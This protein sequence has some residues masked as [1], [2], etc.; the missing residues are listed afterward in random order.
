[1]YAFLTK[2]RISR[3]K[4][5]FMSTKSKK[6][7]KG[8]LLWFRAVLFILPKIV[9][10]YFRLVDLTSR[11][12]H[13]NRQIEEEVCKRKSFCLA[14]FHGA[15]LW[16]TYC[17]RKF[18]GIIMVSRSWDGELI[19]RCLR[20]WGYDTA[21]GSSSKFG[22]EALQDMV[23]LVKE[24]GCNA[25]MAVDAPRGPARVAKIG[26]V[27]IARDTGQ[28]I[29]PIATW[30][31]RHIQFNSWDKMILPLPFGT[32]VVAYGDP[33]HVPKGLSHAGY[34]S[35]RLQLQENINKAQALAEQKVSQISGTLADVALKPVA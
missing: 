27:M 28:P 21:R 16:A 5:G 24:T 29:V 25:G 7:E 33:V 8:D 10:A 18:S 26:A 34:E 31:T 12:V 30:T 19:D 3:R 22:K 17:F 35:L 11:K 9:G 6:K 14:G 2:V 13:I 15:L 1:L 20:H 32:V 4:W 23:N